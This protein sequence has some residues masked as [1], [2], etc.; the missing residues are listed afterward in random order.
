MFQL[1]EIPIESL[2]IT[3]LNTLK[4]FENN[5]EQIPQEINFVIKMKQDGFDI[6]FLN[7][8]FSNSCFNFTQFMDFKSI[9]NM[10]LNFDLKKKESQTSKYV[11]L[12]NGLNLLFLW[13]KN[14]IESISIRADDLPILY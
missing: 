2:S 12:I 6:D 8:S 11:Y 13:F 5:P 14:D 7:L 1:D 3:L 9:F 4:F 10:N